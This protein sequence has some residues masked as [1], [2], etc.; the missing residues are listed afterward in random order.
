[1]EVGNGNIEL[2]HI[3]DA[4]SYNLIVTGKCRGEI[5]FFCDVGIQPCCQRQDFFGWF[6]K[7]L[8]YGDDV[9]YFTEY[10]YE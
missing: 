9:N 1:M 6:E 7:W 2:I 4:Q 10:Q 8:H 5:C 3:G